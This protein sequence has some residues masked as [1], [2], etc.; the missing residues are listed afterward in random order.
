MSI[1]VL[2]PDST[3]TLP[4]KGTV[5]DASSGTAGLVQLAGDLGGT[6]TSPTVVSAS[7][8][9]AGK[10]QLATNGGTTALTAVQAS[11]SRLAK[12]AAIIDMHCG[13]GAL[14]SATFD[15]SSA[16]TGWSRSGSTYT[17]T[18]AG[19]LE[20]STVTL[21]GGVTLVPKGC[22]LRIQSLTCSGS[23]TATIYAAGGNASG[24][25]AG[26]GAAILSN[27]PLRGGTDG[28]VGR[29]TSGTGPNG[30]NQSTAGILNMGG[31]G[32]TGGSGNGNAGGAGGTQLQAWSSIYGGLSFIRRM[33]KGVLLTTWYELAGGTGGGGGGASIGTDGTSG[34]GGGAG[35]EIGLFV[36]TLDT[37]SCTLAIVVDGGNGAN[38]TQGSSGNNSVA[39]GGGGAAGHATTFFGAVTGTVTHSAIGGNGG[40]GAVRGAGTNVSG[41]NGGPGG[42]IDCLYGVLAAG[43]SITGT[44]TGGSAGA[45]AGGG[46]AGSAGANGT[47]TITA[48]V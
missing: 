6:A 37:G 34:A 41:P 46:S 13:S 25:T 24:T 23:G 9:T 47:S 14:G 8:S 30:A 32:G 48:A 44:V 7:T 28:G 1:A 39:G 4:K 11:D 16:V 20:Y 15:G 3:G 36:G 22:I 18:T 2:V 10:V 43:G 29:V 33:L 31:V 19:D 40:N 45:A 27:A 42:R 12:V 5:P 17:A 26:T 38:A 35:G 21:T